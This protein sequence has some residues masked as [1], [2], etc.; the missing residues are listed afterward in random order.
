MLWKPIKLVMNSAEV[1]QG[2]NCYPSMMDWQVNQII[3]VFSQRLLGSFNIMVA[4]VAA[5]VITN[6]SKW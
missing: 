1:D 5:V 3:P 6:A 4:E 2:N